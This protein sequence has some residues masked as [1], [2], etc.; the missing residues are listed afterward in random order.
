MT[1]ATSSPVTLAAIQLL[2]SRY[3]GYDTQLVIEWARVP[4]PNKALMY[5]REMK[6]DFRLNWI[7]VLNG[8]QCSPYVLC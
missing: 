3:G 1:P 7:P 6:L 4:I 5:L 8:K 2:P